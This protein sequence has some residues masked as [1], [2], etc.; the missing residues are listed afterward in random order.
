M[1]IGKRGWIW[2]TFSH[3]FISTAQSEIFFSRSAKCSA[4][5]F[6]YQWEVWDWKRTSVNCCSPLFNS[7]W[8]DDRVD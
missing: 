1:R 7:F 3:D 6:Y 4:F 8:I 2:Q 5:Q